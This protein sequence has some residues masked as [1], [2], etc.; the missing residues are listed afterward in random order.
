LASEHL[1]NGDTGFITAQ[2]LNSK[3]EG[4]MTQAIGDG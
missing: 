4:S 2:P 3:E 1:H